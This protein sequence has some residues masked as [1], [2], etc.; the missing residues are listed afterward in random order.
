MD[1][2]LEWRGPGQIVKSRLSGGV[3]EPN[4]HV[5]NL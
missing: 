5:C 2:L 4:P 3:E 1:P